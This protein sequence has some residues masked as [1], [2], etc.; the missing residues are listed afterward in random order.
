MVKA[1]IQQVSVQVDSLH[2]W[3]GGSLVDQKILHLYSQ[4]TGP[5]STPRLFS[6]QTAADSNEVGAKSQTRA[7]EMETGSGK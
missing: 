2:L 7:Q 6:T 1:V 4:S 3:F 5:H